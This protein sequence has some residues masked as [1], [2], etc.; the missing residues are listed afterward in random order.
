M[1]PLNNVNGIV[2]FEWGPINNPRLVSVFA[3]VT[4]DISLMFLSWSYVDVVSKQSTKSQTLHICSHVQLFKDRPEMT[5]LLVYAKK[6]LTPI[7]ARKSQN[8]THP[9]SENTFHYIK[10]CLMWPCYVT[11]KKIYCI[12]VQYFTLQLTNLNKA[13]I[14]IDIMMVPLWLID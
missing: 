5:S 12:I 8:M 11:L 14:S 9:A 6:G 10:R 3:N 13:E 1:T 4:N 7:W 2:I